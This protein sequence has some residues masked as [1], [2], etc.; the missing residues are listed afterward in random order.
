MTNVAQ[1]IH[2]LIEILTLHGNQPLSLTV[3]GKETDFQVSDFGF[4]EAGTGYTVALRT[5]EPTTDEAPAETVNEDET[6][7]EAPADAVA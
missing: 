2:S 5:I 6:D 4:N 1:T 7:A 3:D